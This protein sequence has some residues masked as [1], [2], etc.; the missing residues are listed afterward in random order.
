MRISALNR[1]FC[2]SFAVALSLAVSGCQQKSAAPPA[3]A[4]MQALPVKTVAVTLAPV[5]QTSEFVATILSR[6][7]ATIQ[8]QVT[9]RLTQIQVKS[10]D[11]VK[12]GQMMMSI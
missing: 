6:R 11:H 1:T 9:G 8:P 12:S 5:A 4:G 3:S 10:G 2:L 7:S